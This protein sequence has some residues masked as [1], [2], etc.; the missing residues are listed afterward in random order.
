MASENKNSENQIDEDILSIDLDNLELP[1]I[2]DLDLEE[3]SDFDSDGS[4]D[5]KL[6]D[7]F[8]IGVDQEKDEQQEQSE[9]NEF[10]IV[11]LDNTELSFEGDNSLNTKELDETEQNT[12]IQLDETETIGITRDLEEDLKI[13]PIEIDLTDESITEENVEDFGKPLEL[14]EFSD[15]ESNSDEE[16]ISLTEKE[17]DDILGDQILPP[18][19]EE[20]L[21][22]IED[23]ELAEKIISDSE[24]HLSEEHLEEIQE[25]T[26]LPPLSEVE[27]E[28][29][30]ISLTPEELEGIVSSE[31]LQELSDELTEE[32]DEAQ[33][34]IFDQ[35]LQDI[36]IPE[37]V[38]EEDSEAISLTDEELNNIIGDVT[39]EDLSGK[40]TIPEPEIYDIT[41]KKSERERLTED[42]HQEIGLKKEELKKI[43]SYLDS[44]FDKLPDDV[45]REFSRSEYFNLYRK[46]IETL[47]IYPK[48]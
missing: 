29:E 45:I 24:E 9:N 6:N 44:L 46:V 14:Q 21:L 7:P 19:E 48:E 34:S 25:D 33:T 18:P 41:D 3:E 26:H 17:L 32:V 4:S 23:N 36:E 38:F 42:L 35:E 11:S 20:D 40:P 13:E 12:N 43:I 28:E 47:E 8:D 16:S 5:Q 27:M 15:I 1:E 10:D 22:K 37:P 31:N 2:P 39:T 30:T